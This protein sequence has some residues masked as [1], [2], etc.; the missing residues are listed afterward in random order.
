MIF[1]NITDFQQRMQDT[2]TNTALFQINYHNCTIE[3]I[4]SISQNKFLFA[5]VDH[6]IGFTCSLNH[7][8]ASAFINHQDAV[9][10]LRL[11]REHGNWDPI[12]FYEFL[13]NQLPNIGFNQATHAEYIQTLSVSVSNFEDRIYFNHWRN[14][15]MSPAQRNKTIELMGY[16]VV[17]FC[18]NNH[19]IP[20]YFDHP[21]E[22]T[23]SA[24]S[25]FELD[26][27]QNNIEN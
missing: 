21:T 19:I 8:S 5:F 26:Y 10:Q 18:S 4:Y 15:N 7:D 22:R 25:N 1:T 11:C 24:F 3:C 2:N 14:S 9:E 12:H 6:N 17:D 20:I 23:L 16:A 27:Q 13:N